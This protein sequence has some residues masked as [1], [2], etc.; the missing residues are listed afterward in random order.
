MSK[1]LWN[2]GE[3]CHWCLLIYRITG[4]RL[5]VPSSICTFSRWA[6]IE[7]SI[8][9][10]V[11]IIAF[12]R[13]LS[14]LLWLVIAVMI[15][16]IIATARSDVIVI[17]KGIAFAGT[18][19][20]PPL[21]PCH[22]IRAESARSSSWTRTGEIICL[23]TCR[24]AFFRKCRRLQANWEWRRLG[25]PLWVLLLTRNSSLSCIRTSSRM[26]GVGE[27]SEIDWRGR[28]WI[29][30]TWRKSRAPEIHVVEVWFR[31]SVWERSALVR[32]YPCHHSSQIR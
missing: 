22:P 1:G 16:V 25:K 28:F 18:F 23:T 3:N 13:G 20:L 14:S 6:W 10:H 12:T 7:G 32:L 21:L 4:L 19:L 9:R 24:M 8:A 31:A 2:I 26:S 30:P 11:I 15:N 17:N 27:C 29:R 5:I